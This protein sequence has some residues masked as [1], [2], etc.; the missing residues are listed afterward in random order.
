MSQFHQDLLEA[1]RVATPVED[2]GMSWP[3]KY[4]HIL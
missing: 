2:D 1:P 3:S 4:I